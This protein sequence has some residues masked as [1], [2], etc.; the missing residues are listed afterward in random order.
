MDAI[1]H[2]LAYA[3]RTLRRSPGFTLITIVILALGIGANTAI[4]S[5]INAVMLRQL[6]V[7]APSELVHL[8]SV[9]PGEPRHPG[10]PW[11]AYEHYRDR[12]HV[13]S[14]MV[15]V[16]PAMFDVSYGGADVETVQAQYVSGNFFT[17][18][19]VHPALGRLLNAQDDVVGAEGAAVAVLSWGTWQAR[20]G[21]DPAITGGRIVVDGVPMT[22][23]GVAPRP[24]AGAITGYAPAMFLPAAAEAILKRPSGRASGLMPVAV[25][26]RLRPGTSIEQA[27]AE[28]R[29]LD[30]WRVQQMAKRSKDSQTRNIRMDVAPAGAG[31]T[32]M[33]DEVVGPLLVIMIVVGLLLLLACANVGSM[34][35]A[36]GAARQ[37]EL[38]VRVS[39]GASPLRLVRQALAESLLL[40]IA[41]S[42]A[43]IFIGVTGARVLERIFTSGKRLPGVSSEWSLDVGLD[44]NVLLFTAAVGVLTAVLFG[45][46]PALQALAAAP[47]TALRGGSTETRS[48][49]VL[50]KSLV[51]AQVAL[52][53]VVLSA[54]ALFVRHLSN[55]KNIGAGFESDSVLLVSLDPAR[56]GLKPPEVSRLYGEL[57]ARLH[58]IPGVR[59]ATLSGVTPIH[60]AGASRF[61]N[62]EGKTEDPATRRYVAVNWVA[63]RYFETFGT[64]LV[65]GRDVAP[66]DDAGPPVAI[67]NQA[68]A[69]HFFGDANPLGRYFT[70][71]PGNRRYEIAGVA[72]DAK[73]YTLHE[74]PPQTVYL[75]AF[76]DAPGRNHQFALRT[77]VAPLRVAGDVR[78][79]VQ[80]VLQNVR[81]TKITT[82][83]D[84]VNASLV[85]ERLIATLSTMFGT[86][87]AVL[88]AVGLY[89]LLA[90]TVSRRTSEIGIRMALGATAG[91]VMRLVGGSAAGLVL[92]GVVLGAPLAFW[93]RSIVA[94]L[95]PNLKAEM[96]GS[97]VIAA[98][99]LM[100]AAACA[101]YVPVRR[102]TQVN[103][104]EALRQS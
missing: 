16:S 37:R 29:V 43:G 62:V 49:R 51:V 12:N 38:A 42:I 101:A 84:Q 5:V 8:L 98:G 20:F 55:L 25:I 40:S 15:A 81:V 100:V 89:G 95:I 85:N 54:A 13:F 69:R 11:A 32:P 66:T 99:A 53:L 30:Q 79:A 93:C 92:S 31:I 91:H 28:M 58:A 94:G 88:A 67:V 7:R 21:G 73:Y 87:A 4:F 22:I 34:L 3:A 76:Q 74:P 39:L 80:E 44:L 14:D 33:R 68:F 77:A 78:R 6:P 64:P 104:V 71:D 60:G 45:L 82:L 47:M 59:S 1:R 36:R 75:S 2:D 50:G 102:A 83:E 63:P 19:G 9:Y 23:A 35:L 103:P 97:F 57:L 56:S 10:F 17:A 52:S 41:G 96:S 90:F 26:G 70:F 24:F 48:R 72:G 86:L 27:Q 65:A 46:A 61:V 18:L